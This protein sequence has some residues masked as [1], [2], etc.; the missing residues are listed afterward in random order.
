LLLPS[1]KL[2]RRWCD[3]GCQKKLWKQVKAGE[4]DVNTKKIVQQDLNALYT[5]D[6]IA[7]HYVYAQNYT[8]LWCV[9][10]Y[11]SG[12]PILYPFACIFYFVL[13]WVYKWLLLKFYARTTRFNQDIPIQS[14]QWIK[15]GI[16]FHLAAGSFMLSNDRFFPQSQDGGGRLARDAIDLGHEDASS[17]FLSTFFKR[18][19]KGEQGSVY[20]AFICL[21]IAFLFLKYTVVSWS[22]MFCSSLYH[23]LA[24]CC[25]C[26]KK[27]EVKSKDIYKEYTVLSLENMYVKAMK[28]IEEFGE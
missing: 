7:S 6:Q 26:A 18:M 16:A 2:S 8:Y 20:L 11:S 9:L 12:L 14:A 24:K 19:A 1:I 13:Y 22:I 21:L 25:R 17:F 15:V 4:V 23:C 27:H 5:G 28:D 3:R 10:L